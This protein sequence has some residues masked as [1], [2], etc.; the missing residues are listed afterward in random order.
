MEIDKETQNKI[1]EMQITEQNLQIILMQK[2]AFQAEIN[3]VEA[4]LEEVKSSG[5]EIYRVVGQIMIKS[6]KNEITKELENKKNLLDLRMKSVNKQ[7]ELLEKKF[8]EIKNEVEKSMKKR[9]EK[10]S[11]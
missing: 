5:E 4:A 10:T 9:K 11:G 2:Q 1:Q 8:A 6:K 7:E 3:E